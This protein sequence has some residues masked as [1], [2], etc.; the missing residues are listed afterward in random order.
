MVKKREPILMTPEGVR[1][2]QDE[3]WNLRYRRIPEVGEALREMRGV[4]GDMAEG[5]EVQVLVEELLQLEER[6]AEVEAILA[7]VEVVEEEHS[8]RAQLGSWV[9]I[10]HADGAEE[11]YRLVGAAEADPFRG[12]LSVASPLGKSL[13]GRGVG[14]EVSWRSP[15]GPINAA[16]ILT[17]D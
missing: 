11:H 6:V 3:L 1:R 14:E 8:G 16:T 4:A 9:V 10:R 15:G 5:G 13:L 2:L 7:Q 12:Q 17:I